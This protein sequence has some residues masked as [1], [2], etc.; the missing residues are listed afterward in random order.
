MEALCTQLG[1]VSLK[2]RA[3]DHQPT[4]A[5]SS[6]CAWVKYSFTV[7][8]S[9]TRTHT[10]V[11]T[12]T[13][14]HTGCKKLS[15]MTCQ[16]PVQQFFTDEMAEVNLKDSVHGQKDTSHRPVHWQSA[17]SCYCI[18][19]SIWGMCRQ[20]HTHTHTV[21]DAERL[22]IHVDHYARHFVWIDL[23]GRSL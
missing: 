15:P 21:K 13:H 22:L 5:K 16:R 14:T 6:Y 2:K 1:Q 17:F 23:C 18:Q 20:T 4:D 19:F 12:P 3:N 7:S 10:G 11:K 9:H 8:L